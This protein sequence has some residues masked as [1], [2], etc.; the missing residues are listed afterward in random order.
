MLRKKANQY[1]LTTHQMDLVEELVDQSGIIRTGSL[2]REGSIADLKSI[3]KV[4]S[5]A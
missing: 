1:Y 2:V 5:V 4:I 3:F